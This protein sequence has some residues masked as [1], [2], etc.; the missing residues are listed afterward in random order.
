MIQIT[1]LSLQQLDCIASKPLSYQVKLKILKSLYFSKLSYGIQNIDHKNL[2]TVLMKLKSKLFKWM[3]K[4]RLGNYQII[5]NFLDS[6]IS[7]FAGI[8]LMKLLTGNFKKHFE[9]KELIICHRCSVV[10]T[11]EHF[12]Q[13]DESILFRR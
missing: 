5:N 1:N 12:M 6:K 8:G 3:F 2:S 11:Q 4:L 13:C 9:N 7:S 10:Q